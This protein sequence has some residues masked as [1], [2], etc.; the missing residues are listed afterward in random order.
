MASGGGESVDQVRGQ[1]RGQVRGYVRD[2]CRRVVVREDIVA[3]ITE[4]APEHRVRVVRVV[5]GVV[6]LQ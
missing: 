1:A 2:V 4:R 5:R 6:V 3:K